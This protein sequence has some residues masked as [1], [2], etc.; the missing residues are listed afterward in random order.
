MCDTATLLVSGAFLHPIAACLSK[1]PPFFAIVILMTFVA[2]RN[3][4]LS[5]VLPL[6]ILYLYLYGL[7]TFIFREIL[8][9]CAKE[10]LTFATYYC[11]VEVTVRDQIAVVISEITG[12]SGQHFSA[13]FLQ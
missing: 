10:H 1:C 6:E 4:R 12:R 9:A 5:M 8:P 13:R 3:A 7:N 11:Q 2:S